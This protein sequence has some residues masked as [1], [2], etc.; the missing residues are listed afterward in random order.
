M[1]LKEKN[2]Y[3][4]VGGGTFRLRSGK[5][6]KPGQTFFAH[7]HDIPEAFLL[8]LTLLEEG[9]PVKT[10]KPKKEEPVLD[11]TK[12]DEPKEEEKLDET[13]NDDP[14]KVTYEIEKITIGWYNVV[15]SDGKV[16]NEKKLRKVAADAL[17]ESLSV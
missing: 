15:D 6:I 14:P 11:E 10:E 13:K 1:Q 7:K 16:M 17:V 5:I 3:K 8:T 9:K 12:K 4:K 2:K